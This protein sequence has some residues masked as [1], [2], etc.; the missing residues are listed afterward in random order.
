[1]LEQAVDTQATTHL[2][3]QDLWGATLCHWVDVPQHFEDV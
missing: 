1:M 2:S 3:I